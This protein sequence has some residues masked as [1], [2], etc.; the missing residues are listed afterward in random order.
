MKSLIV[1]VL[2]LAVI[3]Q[4][5]EMVFYE[6]NGPAYKGQMFGKVYDRQDWLGVLDFSVYGWLQRDSMGTCDE[7]YC[8]IF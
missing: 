6:W 2:Y 8:T 4:C 5:Q 7:S 3:V 1:I